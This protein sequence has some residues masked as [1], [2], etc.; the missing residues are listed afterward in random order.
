MELTKGTIRPV[1]AESFL[2][3]VDISREGSFQELDVGN[4]RS[5]SFLSA[6]PQDGNQTGLKSL[7]FS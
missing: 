5:Y 6:K 4:L 3:D 1:S 7:T 2:T